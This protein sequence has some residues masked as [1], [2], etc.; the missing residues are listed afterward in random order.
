VPVNTTHCDYDAAL[1]DWLRA[2]DV[3]A[4]EDVVKRAGVRYLPRLDSQSDEEFRAYCQRA[5][6]FNGTSRTAEGYVG[7][8]FR[9][10]PF[11]KIPKSKAGTGVALAE[12]LNDADMLGTPLAAY[13]KIVV[14]EVVG[15]GRAGSLVDWEGLESRAYVCLYSAEQII[16][17]RVE[18]VNGRNVPTLIVLS[19]RSTPSGGTGGD[20][21]MDSSSEQIRVLKLVPTDG[22]QITRGKRDYRCEVELW[23][24]KVVTE[25]Q[26][27]CASARAIGSLRKSLFLC[28]WAIRSR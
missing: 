10:P 11:L 21:F 22:A 20:P 2:R 12:F 9:R 15:L 7:L 25:G 3:L 5:A 23:R 26:P 6:F 16:N 19:E 1:P 24:P 18:R 17:W 8:I 13:A 4:G 28:G 27:R 14:A